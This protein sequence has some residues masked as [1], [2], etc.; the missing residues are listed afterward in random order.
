MENLILIPVLLTIVA[1]ALLYAFRFQSRKAREIFL[2]VILA[3]NCAVVWW[4]AFN[5]PEEPLLIAR[6]ADNLHLTFFVDGPAKIFSCLVA[7]L[8]IPATLYAFDYMEHEKHHLERTEDWVNSFFTFYTMTCGITIGLAYAGNP[9]TMYV[10]FEALSLVTLP[11]VIHLQNNRS[12][13]AGRK[14]LRYM[15]GGAAF[16][17]ITLVFLVVYG[18]ASHF[19]V[20]G[21]IDFSA[22][23]EL[24]EL[25]LLVY[26]CGF[27]GFGVKTA[28]FPLGDWLISAS[29]APS[30]VTALLH[31]VAVVKAGAFVLIRLT[32]YCFGAENLAGTW[33]QYALF[34]I[35]AFTICYG[36]T[37]AVKETHFKRRL[38]YSTMSNLSYILLGVV[39]MNKAGMVAAFCHLVFHAFMKIC[40]FFCA[41][42][43]MQ[44]GD[45]NYVD[46]LDGVGKEMP[47]V[48]GCFTIAGISL[49]GIPPLSGFVSKWKL[50]ESTIA[51]ADP[52]LT[53]GA[54]VLLYSAL[55]TAIYILTIVVRAWFPAKGREVTNLTSSV[56][57]RMKLPLVFFTVVIVLF[58][59]NAQPLI[60]FL[61]SLM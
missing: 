37:M 50:A 61:E 20:S 34:A 52:I 31:A 27:L 54:A 14:Y 44:R 11:L 46:E 15:L 21:I 22:Y 56:G 6:F 39:M 17:F 48:M 9:L 51:T 59:L 10:F 60:S 1:G 29:V 35:V 23:P 55:L 42:V 26:L 32:F 13:R 19:S 30:P 16:G 3:V 28:L 5:A 41:G 18:D 57:W 33:V 4:I 49:I 36:S 8:W 12:V 38:A 24:T 7:T 25:F 2:L 58:G 47:L 40:C 45:R 43:V 53:L